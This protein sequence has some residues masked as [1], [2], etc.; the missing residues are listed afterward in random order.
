ML[1]SNSNT[2]LAA[3]PNGLVQKA[4]AL[5][6]I[7]SILEERDKFVQRTFGLNI[8]NIQQQ[9]PGG[10]I[11]SKKVEPLQEKQI[12]PHSENPVCL[13]NT[14]DN[15]QEC[16][17]YAE[18]I[19]KWTRTIE[20]KY[21]VK[22]NYMITQTD[23]NEKMRAILV[24][25][26]V[27]VHMKFKLNEETLF[28]SVNILDRFLEKEVVMRQKLQLVGVTAMLIA[29]KYEEIYPPEI[30][31]FVYISDNAYTKP[32][33]L[34]MEQ[35]ILKTLNYDLNPPSAY[36]F[37]MRYS[38]RLSPG[39]RAHNMSLYLIE[40]ALMEY[41]FLKYRPSILASAALYLSNR[42]LNK[43]NM[44]DQKIGDH[45]GYK[46]PM[47]KPCAKELAAIM[48]GVVKTSLQAVKRKYSLP[49]YMEVSNI[50]IGKK[51]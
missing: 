29:S 9:K 12:P 27:D 8:S 3:P 31:D 25:W 37:L 22:A 4:P 28:L 35:F 5:R 34:Q 39:T 21:S 7:T 2:N 41:K 48:Q 18:E 16:A 51:A 46:E 30:K 49:Q 23:I 40:L 38:K 13:S 43:D 33:V 6:P 17:E 50:K 1:C 36:R 14:K 15:I 47:I 24:D 11:L 26:M 44:W 10:F 32:E 45:I 20:P 42:L 19:E